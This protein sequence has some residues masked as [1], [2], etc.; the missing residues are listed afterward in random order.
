MA[1]T[2]IRAA[3]QAK[4]VNRIYRK[5]GSLWLPVNSLFSMIPSLGVSK[6]V[7]ASEIVVTITSNGTEVIFS[8]LFTSEE[9]AS[10]T[11]K[12]VNIAS[13][14][15]IVGN[16][17]DWAAAIQPGGQAVTWG[18][19]LIINNYGSILGRGGAPNGGRG[20]NVIYTDPAVTWSKKPVFN[21]YGNL[22]AGGGAGGVGGNGGGGYWTQE[23]WEGWAYD[24][25]SYV[26][27]QQN[28]N[29]TAYAVWG[30]ANKGTV[31]GS[32]TTEYD[33]N[34]GW[35][36]YRG[37]YRDQPISGS[38][39][40][41]VGRRRWQNNYTSGGA[42]G[43]GGNGQ[44]SNQNRSNGIGGSGGGTNAGTGGTGGNGGDW[45][46]AGSAGNTGGSGNNGGGAGGQA[47]GLAGI[48]YRSALITM[49]NYGDLRGRVT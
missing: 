16:G 35:R 11:T 43:N 24:G 39:R 23:F 10:D 41:E 13:G 30:G 34:D 33:G 5:A 4:K 45:G 25:S 48:V 3:S 22:F 21:N 6:K 36:Y 26:F 9:W 32:G 47:G 8:N 42:G 38:L 2:Y 44:G 46:V 29:N 17:L 12:I 19:L 1:N 20:G 27:R 49:N 18:G 14:V 28:S 15:T 40:Y 31:G 7:F 37:A